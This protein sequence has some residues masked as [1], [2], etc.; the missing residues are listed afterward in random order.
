MAGLDAL[1][2]VACEH[3]F[4]RLWCA[5]EAVLKAHGHGISF[6]LH[7]QRF[8]PDGAG[9][10]G[11]VWFTRSFVV[12]GTGANVKIAFTDNGTDDGTGALLDAVSL[13]RT[14]R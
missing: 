12:S 9:L 14:T 13:V 4:F 6:G 10:S 1:D 2:D 7:K 11:P 5:K 3:W 8:A